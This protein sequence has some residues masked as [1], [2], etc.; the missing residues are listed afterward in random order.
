LSDLEKR[1]IE[2]YLP[3]E[4]LSLEAVSEKSIR[5][6]HI[7]MLHLWWARRPLVA[8]R[9]AVYGALASA[10]SSAEERNASASFIRALCVYPGDESIFAKAREEVLLAHRAR[11]GLD[12]RPK[13]LDLFS[14]GGAIS[15][16]ALRLGADAFA[17]ELNPVAYLINLC[18]LVYPQ[19]YGLSDPNS[20][21][22]GPGG[23]WRGIAEEVR[24]WGDAVL[25]RVRK[26]IGDLYPLAK[27]PRASLRPA[28]PGEFWSTPDAVPAGFL[29]PSAYIWTR[30]VKCKKPGC[31]AAIPLARQTWLCRKSNSKRSRFVGVDGTWSRSA[32]KMRFRVVEAEKQE[33]LGFDPSA[34]SRGGETVCPQCRASIDEQYVKAEGCAGRL[35]M[36]LMAVVC[37]PPEGTGKQYINP[38]EAWERSICD[39][40]LLDRAEKI[41]KDA[42]FS[43]PDEP[44]EANPRSFD[45]QHFGF[46]HWRDVFTARQLVAV[47]AFTSAIRVSYDDMIGGG[48]IPDAAKGVAT[49]LSMALGR[50]INQCTSLCRWQ[51]EFVAG[52]LGD[53][54]L[55]MIMDF[56]EV[57]PLANSSGSWANALEYVC[58]TIASFSRVLRPASVVRGSALETSWPDNSF[59]AIV[60]DPPY[61]DSRSYS[62]LSDHFFVWHKRAVGHLYPADFASQLTPKKNE[63]IAAPYR[64]GGDWRAADVFYEGA[65]QKAFA[66]AHRLLK[67]GSPMVCVYAHKTT[68]GWTTLIN[69]MRSAGFAVVEAWPIEMERK[70][71]QNAL[72]TAALASS[73]LLVARRRDETEVGSYE[74]VVR[75]ELETTVR[76][77]VETLW[78]S[79]IQGADLVVATVGAGLRAFTRFARVEFENGE[80]VPAGTFLAEVET[81]VLDSILERLSKDVGANGNRYTLTGI[82]TET[83]FYVLWRY[84]FRWS[85]LDAG[86]AIIFANGTHLELEQVCSGTRP[87]LEKK[88]TKYRLFTYADRG[89]D[90][91]LG[92]PRENGDSAP[93][94]DVLH[95]LLWLMENRPRE[96]GEFLREVDPNREQLRLLSQALAGPALRGGELSD[97]SPTAELSVLAKLTAN[98]RSVV[99]D[100]AVASAEREDRRTGQSKLR[101]EKGDRR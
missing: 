99:E 2:D 79:G 92:S 98:W 71:R 94:V 90:P 32:K 52:M 76:E 12:T 41:A 91:R 36:Q 37:E 55:P 63:A 56:A 10:P 62:N 30:T 73:I 8:A 18:T 23:K 40:R 25:A 88:Q 50:L 22:S 74:R 60:T 68:S 45:V 80:E 46:A 95:R 13:V 72:E 38:D 89:G 28:L 31:G 29:V 19:K 86:E 53:A 84:T 15:L 3:I 64:H 57:N 101:F 47:A 44:L 5:Q 4:H 14:G 43:L 65:M 24:Y 11:T 75:P 100:A 17:N 93:L 48:Y 77:R 61:Y 67:P 78:S 85:E 96:I 33:A 70:A 51:P 34:G 82:D 16:E 69:A 97:V 87:L 9:A 35:D 7:S 6:A 83:R 21:G 27:D 26:Q 59:D 54:G 58:G 42:G 20:V 1:L 66:E 81:V 49:C 39:K